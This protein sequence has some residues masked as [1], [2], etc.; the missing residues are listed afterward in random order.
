MVIIGRYKVSRSTLSVISRLNVLLQ[1]AVDIMEKQGAS[2]ADRPRHVTA[3]EMLSGGLSI[4]FT[5][6]GERFR[7]MRRFVVCDTVQIAPSYIAEHFIRICSLKHLRHMSPC[8]CYMQRP[9]S[10]I[11]LM[12]QIT[13]RTI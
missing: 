9:Q 2:V 6:A 10:S 12:I 4:G 1:A 8:R 13:S 5:R 11:F 3:G 7:R